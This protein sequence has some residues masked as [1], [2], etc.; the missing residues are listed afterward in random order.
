MSPRLAYAEL[1]AGRQ[2]IGVGLTAEVFS[3]GDQRVLKLFFSWVSRESAELEFVSTDAIHR[4]GVAT[5]AALE[6]VEIDGRPGIV[7]ERIFGESL[8]RRVER[9]PWTLFE[10]ARRLAEL[11]AGIHSCKSPP[12]LQTQHDQLQRWVDDAEALDPAKKE[13]TRRQIQELPKGEV[14]CHG[15]FHPGNILLAPRGPAIIDWATA[16]RGNAMADVARTSALFESADLPPESPWHTQLLMKIAR[17]LL[18]ATYLKRYLQIAPGSLEE[19]ETG[20][21]AQRAAG[22][23]WRSAHAARLAARSPSVN[24]S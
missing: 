14:L 22:A 23:A 21:V 15:D 3:W 2:R 8:L 9:R 6:M 4:T 19:I 16:S 11:H 12:Q 1:V 10:G 5:P 24:S 17:R 20:R 7:F 18:H 13:A